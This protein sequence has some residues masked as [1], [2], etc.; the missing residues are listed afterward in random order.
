M[1]TRPWSVT[2]ANHGESAAAQAS[3]VTDDVGSAC[4]HQAALMT[5]NPPA[6]SAGPA[7]QPA[8]DDRPAGSIRWVGWLFFA[9]ITIVMAGSIHALTGFVALFANEQYEITSDGLV[10]AVDY[11]TWGWIHLAL[12]LVAVVTGYAIMSGAT[13]AKVSGVILAVG[14]AIT[15]MLFIGAYPVWGVVVIVFDVITIYAL[16]AHGRDLAEFTGP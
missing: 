14:S 13:W 7:G 2:W 5:E 9:A 16:A 11:T 1:S 15:S 6:K 12:G 10:V 4:S 3:P 8:E